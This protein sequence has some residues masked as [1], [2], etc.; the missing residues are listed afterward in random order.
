MCGMQPVLDGA[1]GAAGDAGDLS[2]REAVVI[3]QG[4]RQ[5][6]VIWQAADSL[7]DSRLLLAL[8][9]DLLD[10]WI[11]PLVDVEQRRERLLEALAGTALAQPPAA[12]VQGDCV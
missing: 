10:R 5:S 3:T 9:G 12:D 6:L 2:Q 8:Q 1:F 7:P 4:D 11:S